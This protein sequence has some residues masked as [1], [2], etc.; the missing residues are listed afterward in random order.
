MGKRKEHIFY[1]LF[2]FLRRFI[3][4]DEILITS[5]C[6]RLLDSENTVNVNFAK[7]EEDS[8]LIFFCKR[9]VV[10]VV[11]KLLGCNADV[12]YAGI[13][14]STVLHH[15]IDIHGNYELKL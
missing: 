10:A 13:G 8:P 15:V 3:T 7:D 14:G 12:N 2:K 5:I 1:Q 6:S 11:E 4:F 9:R